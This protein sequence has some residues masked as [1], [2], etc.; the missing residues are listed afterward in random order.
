MVAMQALRLQP[1]AHDLGCKL[2]A[3]GTGGKTYSLR[4]T[5]GESIGAKSDLRI[6]EIFMHDLASQRVGRIESLWSRNA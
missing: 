2:I 1:I 3:R 5:V 4:S 6:T